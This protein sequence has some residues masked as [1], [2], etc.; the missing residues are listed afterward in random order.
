[1][2]G[3]FKIGDVVYPPY[4]PAKAGKVIAVTDNG[5][6]PAAQIEAQRASFSG[7]MSGMKVLTIMNAPPVQD[8]HRPDTLT[9]KR[10]N[11]QTYDLSALHAQSFAALVED[12]ERKA[13]K[14]RETLIACEAVEGDR[15]LSAA[16]ASDAVT[17]AATRAMHGKT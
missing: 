14:H 11:G 3:R 5:I 17:R 4:T 13:A 12:H 15:E 1:M 8:Y 10:P 7:P 16:E 9:V 6:I 2:P